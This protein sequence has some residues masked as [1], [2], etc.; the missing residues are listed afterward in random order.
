MDNRP[1]RPLHRTIGRIAAATLLLACLNGAAQAQWTWRDHSGR[2]N[3]SDRPPPQDIAEK[4]ILSRP[5]SRRGAAAPLPA[6]A[7]QTADPS[8]VAP[9]AASAPSGA[10]ERAVEA[11]KQAA[12]QDKAAKDKAEAERLA[13]ARAENCRRA[14]NQQTTLESGQRMARTNDKGEREILDDKA[15][16][17]ELQRA[18]TVIGSDCR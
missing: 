4:D 14:R 5:P 1:A 8:A 10:L 2:I 6:S 13:T 15:R 9:S 12:E 18:R 3:A 7:G 17:E 16:A 11:R